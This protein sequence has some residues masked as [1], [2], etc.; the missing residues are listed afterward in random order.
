MS[1]STRT[2]A[3]VDHEVQSLDRVRRRVT[4]IGFLAITLHAV[5][6]LPVLAQHLVGQ[7]RD[8]DAALMLALTGLAGVLIVVIARLILGYRR[9][10]PLWTV[11]GLLPLAAGIY[12]AWWAP[13]A[14]H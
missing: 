3:A 4:V 9:F 10:S 12:L 7:G 2:P 14:L 13:F 6:A 1:D 8:A 5:I 11:I